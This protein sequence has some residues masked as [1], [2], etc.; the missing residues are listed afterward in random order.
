ME[1][2]LSLLRAAVPVLLAGAARLRGGR[3]IVRILLLLLGVEKLNGLN[4]YDCM[5]VVWRPTVAEQSFPGAHVDAFDT[6]GTCIASHFSHEDCFSA[7]DLQADFEV[8]TCLCTEAASHSSLVT[9][10]GPKPLDPYLL[11]CHRSTPYLGRPQTARSL[12]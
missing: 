5:A 7:T 4:T 9:T 6:D 10:F 11:E 8:L 3:K 12:L 1:A 2:A